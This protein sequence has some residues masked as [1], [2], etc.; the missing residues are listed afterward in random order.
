MVGNINVLF[1]LFESHLAILIKIYMN[2]NLGQA[3]PGISSIDKPPQVSKNG[4][5]KDVYCHIAYKNQRL[6]KT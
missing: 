3:V 6:G 5:I 1:N 2:W 4:T